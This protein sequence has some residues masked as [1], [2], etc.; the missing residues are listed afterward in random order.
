MSKKVPYSTKGDEVADWGDV[1][2]AGPFIDKIKS[3]IASDTFKN[4]IAKLEAYR[5][6]LEGHIRVLN[7]VDPDDE[8]EPPF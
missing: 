5:R 7:G 2:G 4:V 6:E 3:V 1:E 8:N